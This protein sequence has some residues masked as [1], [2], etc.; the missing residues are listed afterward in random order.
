[1][2]CAKAAAEKIYLTQ[3]AVSKRIFALESHLNQTLFN[4]LGRGVQ[5]TEAGQQLIPKAQALIAQAVD[6][7]RHMQNFDH[8]IKGSLAIGMSHHVGLH[9]LPKVFGDFI[10][11]FRTST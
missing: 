8:Q 3:P 11:E 7:E 6:I 10:L 4:R 2:P 5:L 1:M 9:R